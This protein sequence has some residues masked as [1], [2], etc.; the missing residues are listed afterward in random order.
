MKIFRLN[1]KINFTLKI[2]K[3]SS[4]SHCKFSHIWK[5][6]LTQTHLC[7]TYTYPSLAFH[8]MSS[9]SPLKYVLSLLTSA[10]L[11]S[12]WHSYIKKPADPY[13]IFHS[14]AF[15]SPPTCSTK[16]SLDFYPGS[17]DFLLCIAS[18]RN[19]EYCSSW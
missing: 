14:L 12:L 9:S 7:P 19:L 4:D 10:W 16:V 5:V 18:L 11:P 3:N 17:L 1:H 15:F 8:V 2:G 13:L 6:N